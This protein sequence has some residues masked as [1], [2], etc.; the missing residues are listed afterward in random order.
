VFVQETGCDNELASMLLRFTNGDLDGARRILKSIPKDIHAVKAKFVAE[1]SGSYGAFFFC[2]DEKE[3][4]VKRCI[5]VISDDRKI[6]KVDVKKGWRDFEEDMYD[7]LKN[8]FMDA[9]RIE[10]FG[11]S[12]QSKEF[13]KKIGAVFRTGKQ[14]KNE[15][16]HDLLVGILYNIFPDTNIAVKYG[17]ETT[18]AFELNKGL[19]YGVEAAAEVEEIDEK[20]KK[21]TEEGVKQAGGRA[22]QSFVILKVDPVLSPVRGTEISQLEFGDE[23]Q[24]KITDERKIGEY[25]SDLIGGR[26]QGERVPVIAKVVEVQEM[27][28]GYASVLT[29][30]GPGVMGLF[31]A[32]SEVRIATDTEI[33]EDHAPAGM[34]GREINTAIV[35]G[36]IVLG[37]VLFMLLLFLSR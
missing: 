1:T 14:P 21:I 22:D 2:Y 25:L 32:L 5:S 27:E 12:V 3:N 6:G 11:K 10:Q 36:G 4:R 33:E 19:Q 35:V 18:D 15:A 37:V 7:L 8:S 16:V 20:E 31:R 30:F 28:E 17:L 34:G 13:L 24:V 23:I 9:Q 26:A 29:Q